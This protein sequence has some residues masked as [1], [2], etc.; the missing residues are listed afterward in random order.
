M[1]SVGELSTPS[2]MFNDDWRGGEGQGGEGMG[3]RGGTLVTSSLYS[4]FVS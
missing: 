3:G 4:V 1:Y 2:V